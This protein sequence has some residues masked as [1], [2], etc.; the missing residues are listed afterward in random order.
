[1]TIVIG[2]T[3]T[4]REIEALADL[5]LVTSICNGCWCS[6][7]KPD[8]KGL[9]KELSRELV[10]LMRRLGQTITIKEAVGYLPDF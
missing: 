1:M 10:E 3:F 9:Q 7:D 6:W 2:K 5:E 4:K 8:H